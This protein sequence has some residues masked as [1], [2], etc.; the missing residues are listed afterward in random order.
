MLFMV[1]IIII[2]NFFS[3][4]FYVVLS[5]NKLLLIIIIFLDFFSVFFILYKFFIFL[6]VNI[7]FKL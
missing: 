2:F 5:F 1:L 3:L 7:F 4:N 6:R